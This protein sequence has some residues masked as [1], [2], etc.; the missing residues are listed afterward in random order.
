MPRRRVEHAVTDLVR[1]DHQGPS[2]AQQ[3]ADRTLP[4]ADAAGEQNPYLPRRHDE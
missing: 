1:I 3:L 4:G 2:G